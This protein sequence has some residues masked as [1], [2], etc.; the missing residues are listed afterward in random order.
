[1]RQNTNR[2]WVASLDLWRSN[3][4]LYFEPR[5]SLTFL[6]E[7]GLF[8]RLWRLCC[9]EGERYDI[10]SDCSRDRACTRSLGWQPLSPGGAGE[11]SSELSRGVFRRWSFLR[12]LRADFNGEIALKLSSPPGD[13][14]GV[15]LL[16]GD[17]RE[18]MYL[19]GGVVEPGAV[20]GDWPAL[21]CTEEHWLSD[22][23][24]SAEDDFVGVAFVVAMPITFDTLVLP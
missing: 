6:L 23:I 10:S 20:I 8:F 4:F 21:L 18:L 3:S 11:V 12:L 2:L 22:N 1:M 19:P 15:I 5:S 14:F 7:W 24:A 9:G 17:A 16:P 13:V